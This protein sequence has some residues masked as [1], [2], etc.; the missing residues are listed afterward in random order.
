M[1]H[2]KILLL[3]VSYLVGMTFF[4]LSLR[5]GFY[6]VGEPFPQNPFFILF[7]SH[8]SAIITMLFCAFRF[9]IISTD[10]L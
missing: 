2:L 1:K 6:L 8:L 7:M 5:Y 4:I 3:P 10:W 9:K